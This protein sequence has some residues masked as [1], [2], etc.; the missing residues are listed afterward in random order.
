MKSADFSVA[1]MERGDIELAIEWAAQEGWNPGG[2]DASCFFAT[3]P[4]G[5][6]VGRLGEQPVACI[7]AVRYGASFGFIGLYIVHPEFRK[8]G[9]G[10]QVWKVAMEHLKGRNIGLDGVVEQQDNY[11]KSGFSLAHRNIRYEGTATEGAVSSDLL[12]SLAQVPVEEVMA[13]QSAFFPESRDEFMKAWI[14]APEHQSFAT[15]N[16][17]VITGMGV[18]R[19]CRK[20]FKVGPLWADSPEDARLLLNRLIRDVPKG[21]NFYLDL[22]KPNDAAVGLAE[23]LGVAPVFETARMYTGVVPE[24]SLDRTYGLATFELG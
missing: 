19:P 13:Y 17:G 20:G 24:I 12:V 10:M 11:R 3:D 7:S 1:R 2:D 4:E 5:F 8:R 15:V 14:A 23:S 16:K 22:P 18:I 21:S 9:F 6:F